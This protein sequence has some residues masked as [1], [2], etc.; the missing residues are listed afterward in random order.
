SSNGGT[1]PLTVSVAI[2]KVLTDLTNASIF[3]NSRSAGTGTLYPR[4][5]AGATIASS[6]HYE[7]WRSDTGT[8]L[9]YRTAIV[10]W[11]TAGLT[12]RQDYYRFYVDNNALMPTDPWPAGGADLGENTVLTGADE[13][14]GENETVRIRM[15]IRAMNANFPADTKSWKL[16]YGQMPTTCSAISEDSWNTL[17]DVGSSTI[18]R[19]SNATNLADETQL[20]GNPPTGGDLLLSV[21]D[22]AGTYEEANNTAVNMYAVPEGEDIEYDWLIEQN[23]ANAET[24][25]CF[26]MAE[27]DGTPLGNYAYYP[28]IRTASFTPKT[29]NW[30]WYD[31][32]TSITPTTTLSAEN[33]TP[34]N[35]A[36]GQAVKLRVTVK[37]TENIS[38]DDVRFK[39]QYSEY[40]NFNVADDV[41]A[42]STCIATS[43]WCYANGGGTDNAKIASSTLSDSAS[44]VAGVGS[45]CGTH[46]ESPDVMTGFRHSAGVPTE[47]E[48]TI[49]S[50]GPRVNRVYY[51]RLYDV[52]QDIPVVT[53]TGEAYPSLATEGAS[54]S[55]AMDGL[56]SS[57]VIEG[58]TLD[59]DTTPSSLDFGSLIASST[60][61]GAHRLAVD[62]DGTEGY[63]LLMYMDGDLMSSSGSTIKPITGTNA[64]PGSWA[65]GCS[66]SAPSCFGY[67]TSD[68]TL[69]GGSTRFSA[70]DTYAQVN[71]TTPEIVAYSTQP[72]FGEVTDVIFRII[73][74]ELQEAG[75]YEARIRYISVPMF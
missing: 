53:N 50:A 57:T 27:A 7:L 23:G 13:P 3:M 9:T 60:L 26:R 29:Q 28:Q 32:E 34:V 66:A 15:S 69:E 71:T 61:E 38:R 58:V 73:R 43:T 8:M 55:F 6:T 39:L 48:F 41:V 72:A 16:Q 14:L 19:G 31:D 18:W 56:A 22:R 65:V 24:Y 49:Q 67:H 70:I 1:E 35:I 47:Y 17:G 4:P 64:V 2:G 5:I 68:D 54:L 11:P 20:S 36:N 10:E 25:Y 44:C 33:V 12:F 74:R 51:F 59:I 30:R 21:S 75:L 45:G 37:E 40:A 52:V 46:N 62:T 63:Q 42:T